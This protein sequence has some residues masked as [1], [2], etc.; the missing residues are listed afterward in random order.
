MCKLRRRRCRPC[1][2]RQP[3]PDPLACRASHNGRPGSAAPAAVCPEA[4][5]PGGRHAAAGG[6]AAWGQP[7]GFARRSSRR[8]GTGA[9][10]QCAGAA[11]IQVGAGDTP[12]VA[13]QGQGGEDNRG[14]A[15]W[16]LAALV[17][18]CAGS[19][20]SAALRC[21]CAKQWP[22]TPH[23]SCTHPRC[24]RDSEPVT[25]AFAAFLLT[26]LGSFKAAALAAGRGAFSALLG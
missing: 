20:A 15:A 2:C 16:R 6:L 5:R 17:P 7:C 10:R 12:S 3:K 23:P 21:L 18:P 13:G 24:S 11:G 4:G 8:C 14:G 19:L 1:C 9:R 22:P 25:L 26:W